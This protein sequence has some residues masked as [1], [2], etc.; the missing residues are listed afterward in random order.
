M[1][2]FQDYDGEVVPLSA[3]NQDISDL[4]NRIRGV[5]SGGNANAVSSQGAKG[6]MQIMPGTFK[7]Y[8]LDGESFDNDADRTAAATRKI[9]DDYQYFGGDKAKTAAAYIG[10]RGAIRE[11]GSIRDDVTDAY[12]TSPASY[13]GKVFGTQD[14]VPYDGD[15]I[16]LSKAG[17]GRGMVNPKTEDIQKAIAADQKPEQGL[18]DKVGDT[19]NS[20]RDFGLSLGDDLVR[21]KGSVL[22][23]PAYKPQ[24]PTFSEDIANRKKLQELEPVFE[25]GKKNLAIMNALAPTSGNTAQDVAVNAVA[26][27]AGTVAD[28]ASAIAGMLGA[29]DLSD[30]LKY[31]RDYWAKEADENGGRNF[32]PALARSFGSIAPA[33]L[34]PGSVPAQLVGNSYIFALPAFKNTLEQKLKEGD[35]P[36][37]ALAHASAD[38]GINLAMPFLAQ[39]GGQLV[40]R[41]LGTDGAPSLSNALKAQLSG[42]VAFG[43]LDAGGQLLHKEIDYAQ[44]KQTDA[45]WVDGDK[46]LHSLAL[47]AL[48]HAKPVAGELIGKVAGVGASPIPTESLLNDTA[49]RIP[50]AVTDFHQNYLLN[51]AQRVRESLDAKGYSNLNP[52]EQVA[53]K[54]LT[55]ALDHPAGVNF[56]SLAEL[57]DYNPQ[58][59]TRTDRTEKTPEQKTAD[60]QSAR[61]VDEAITAAKDL[62]TVQVPEG[63]AA[64]QMFSVRPLREVT[65]EPRT[66]TPVTEKPAVE[67]PDIESRRV[68]LEDLDAGLRKQGIYP[69]AVLDRARLD[70]EV[71][72]DDLLDRQAYSDEALRRIATAP[73]AGPDLTNAAIRA[74]RAR[75]EELTPAEVKTLEVK[76]L[77]Q[78]PLEP[79]QGVIQPGSQLDVLH[80]ALAE[81]FERLYQQDIKNDIKRRLGMEPEQA[82]QPTSS[83]FKSFL[84]EYGIQPSLAADI[85]GER[86][87]RANNVLPRT[88]RKDGLNL[89]ALV[90]KAVERGFMHADEVHSDADNGGTNRLVEMIK[91]E[92]RGNR[93]LP[94]DRMQEDAQA[95]HDRVQR[96]ELEH[97]ADRLGLQYPTGLESAKLASMVARVHRRLEEARAPTGSTKEQR[98]I[99]A[100]QEAIARVERKRAQLEAKDAEFDAMRVKMQDDLLE[101]LLDADGNLSIVKRSDI[102]AER[103]WNEHRN[104]TADTRAVEDSQGTGKPDTEGTQAGTR[105]VGEERGTTQHR[106]DA[107]TGEGE[108]GLTSPTRDDV[109]A[110]Q[111]RR[112][113]ADALDRQ[114]QIKR[115]SE[116]GAGSF[117]LTAEDGRQDTT[118]MLFSRGRSGNLRPTERIAPVSRH[119]GETPLYEAMRQLSRN[120]DAFQLRD[121]EAHDLGQIAAEMQSGLKEYSNRFTSS[122]GTLLVRGVRKPTLTLEAKDANG[123]VRPFMHIVDYDTQR[124]YIHIGNE[125]FAT[126]TNGAY[127]YQIGLAWA[128]NNG[129]TM[130][131]DPAGITPINRLRRTEAMIASALH[132]GTTAHM[133]P[134]PDQ[135]IG[136]TRMAQERGI[137]HD[138]TSWNDN[139]DAAHE[140]QTLRDKLWKSGDDP[141]TIATNVNNLI[142]ASLRLTELRFPQAQRYGSIDGR[143]RESKVDGDFLVD[144]PEA[145]HPIDAATL[146]DRVSGSFDRGVGN[147]TL[148]RYALARTVERHLGREGM[149]D[150]KNDGMGNVR[151]VQALRA[152]RSALGD[153]PV[154]ENGSFR[155]ALYSRTRVP[156]EGLDENSGVTT[157]ADLESHIRSSLEHTPSSVEAVRSAIKSLTGIVSKD[158]LGHIVA[159][160]SDRIKDT[161]EPLLGKSVNIESEG[162]AG[163][164]QAFYDPKT[165]TIFMIADH[166][167]AGDEAA[168]L[169]HEL[170]HKWGQEVLGKDGWDR[171]HS[172][173][174]GWESAG[175]HTQEYAVW[176]YANAKV[177]A[178]GHNLSNQELFPYAVE[179]AIKMGIEP[180][181]AAPKGSVSRWLESVR[182]TLKVVWSKITGNPESFKSQDLVDMAF[183]ISRMENPEFHNAWKDVTNDAVT[184]PNDAL[185]KI[186]SAYVNDDLDTVIPN[187]STAPDRGGAMFSRADKGRDESAGIVSNLIHDAISNASKSI[188]AVGTAG[189]KSSIYELV[190][191]MSAGSQRGKAIAQDWINKQRVAQYEWNRIDKIL[192][193][194][195]TPEQREKMWNA[196]D[197]ENDLRMAG[198]VDPSR[199]L[200]RLSKDERAVVEGLHQYSK[201]LWERAKQ[202]GMVKGEG[203][204][205]W[206]PRQMVVYAEDGSFTRPP[207]EGLGGAND[208]RNFSATGGGS[209]KQRKYA[210]SAETEAAMK[211]KGGELV[212]DI[213]TMPL[214]LE[215]LEKGI[216][217][218]E[219]IN[220]IKDLG[221]AVGKDIVIGE[222]RDGYFTLDH[223]AFTTVTSK[224]VPIRLTEYFDR[225]LMD[226]LE[227][228]AGKLGIEHERKGS[229]KGGALGLAYRNKPLVQTKYFTPE[230]VL[231][232]EIGHQIDYKY[233][234]AEQL[235][236]RG[237]TAKELRALAD[238]RFEG[239][240]DSVSNYYREYV[241]KASEKI[242]NLVHAYVHNPERFRE[243]APETFKWFDAFVDRTPELSILKDLGPS[244]TID[245]KEVAAKIKVPEAKKLYIA[246]EFRG[247]LNAILSSDWKGKQAYTGFMLLKSKAMSAIMYSPMI[248]NQVILGRALAYGGIKT[249]LL[250]FSGNAA[251]GDTEFMKKMIGAGMVPIGNRSS[252]LD[253]GD[254]ANGNHYKEGS[255]TDPNESWIGLGVKAAGNKI[256]KGLGDTLKSG[257]DYAGDVW[258][259]KLLWDRVGDL[260]AGIAKDVYTKL[261]AQGLD[262]NAAT[263]VAAHISNRYAG[264]IGKENMSE[265]AHV[266]ANL[267]L[268]SKSFNA[269]NV[270]TVKDALYG[271]P[272]G[273]KAQLMEHS[274]VASAVK[275]LDFAKHKAR[276]GLVRDLVYAIAITSLVQDW[277]KRDKG[278]S[279]AENVSDGLDGYQKRAAEAW[280]NAQDNPLKFNSYNP[281]RLSSTWGNE[282]DKK[283]RVDMGEQPG[284]ARHEYMRLPTGKV[285]E[286]ILGWSM[287][288]G[289]TFSKKESPLLR[290]MQGIA[291]GEKDKYG[292]PIVPESADTLEKVAKVAKFIA[293]THIPIDQIQT[294]RDIKNGH[295]TELDK[296][297]TIGNFTGL[298]FSQ[299]HPQGPEGAVMAKTDERVRGD[300]KSYMEDVRHDVKIG[301]YDAAY[302]RLEKIGLTPKEIKSIIEAI[303]KPKPI[304]KQQRTKFNR[305]A[306]EDERQMMEDLN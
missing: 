24:A 56:N 84:R 54:E 74:L 30:A 126:D 157:R 23:N 264:A 100:A 19:L 90:E 71:R 29:E 247:P 153:V 8:A 159:T 3:D 214:A 168:V 12:G 33:F 265:A 101:I 273:L 255:W 274:D 105:L 233:G 92:I 299:G 161:W 125:H 148:R 279:F 198:T 69:P 140:L 55:T 135:Y 98:I 303:E 176:Q 96:L 208:A 119:P 215:R 283:D 116:A 113:N 302:E 174:S 225:K 269:G 239:N 122:K 20:V 121:S 197:E 207:G 188:D 210:T 10:G 68:S 89:D 304:S 263:T 47:G 150:A 234:L 242:A 294:L 167:R 297:K 232:H 50:S 292:T 192:T 244:L 289:E 63:E 282:P 270:G 21:T 9:L 7:Q 45:P 144:H 281:Y 124:P 95:Q 88:F 171:L 28:S 80:R 211:A 129:K 132:T 219:L 81:D 246:D 82:D 217:G 238:L 41:I 139:P 296:D 162:D 182:Q 26:G 218:R 108:E 231:T 2:D 6:S 202:V 99:R 257:I 194:E 181:M 142:K 61:N 266:I 109:L 280:A 118:G 199:G 57:F 190:A 11:D 42:S 76:P 62:P 133:E 227:E 93:Q 64:T 229:L 248:H 224:E 107:R 209:T 275:A 79:V 261:K 25:R 240:E 49:G 123:V 37:S 130:R 249:P 85:T 87:L 52:V 187:E 301:D 237:A 189:G 86:G 4:I 221:R 206:T 14:F 53:W 16:P 39:H 295:G 243:V 186:K 169:A 91:A 145:S 143:V 103:I 102:E 112:S 58:T 287:H 172:V 66:E 36:L 27:A 254:I 271:L 151:S 111:E 141:A 134:H 83:P 251:K 46:V 250:Y 241:R 163:K 213:R 73:D 77:E 293:S 170:M 51:N 222:S 203:V 32:V 43:G 164:A 245:G 200:G 180:S 262:E 291:T 256:S 179:G 212:R 193:K 173:I 228:L 40:G 226:G 146:S 5:E 284:M 277:V 136:L 127:A 268:F 34:L 298:T 31:S 252:M 177:E 272:A 230:Q 205:F 201:E 288:P 285:V 300:K 149:F 97:E 138:A 165:K 67:P 17:A 259:N 166:I 35:D 22:E 267:A 75:G 65:Q 117:K 137:E 48:L 128:H 160:T 276:I 286:D 290:A 185:R 72:H 147:S 260:Q 70:A 196:A 236:K 78:K 154:S 278:K 178:A 94:V 13:I 216:A 106:S 306:N 223:P 175:K 60:I 114:D 18:W 59:G 156:G 152:I 204:P 235:T 253:V 1:S 44:G 38:A 195:F 305:H 258:H 110:D 15:I 158:K 191:P 183:A 220:Q 104:N 184:N 115:E 155:K 131:P 120:K